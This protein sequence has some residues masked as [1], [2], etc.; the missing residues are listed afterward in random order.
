MNQPGQMN[1]KIEN[2]PSTSNGRMNVK[3]ENRPTTS[4]GRTNV[5][6][7]NQPSTSNGVVNK[8]RSFCVSCSQF[9]YTDFGKKIHHEL[10]QKYATFFNRYDKVCAHLQKNLK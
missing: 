4:N 6:I 7:E 9:L 2:R 8:P 3:I 10:H 1:I 5:K